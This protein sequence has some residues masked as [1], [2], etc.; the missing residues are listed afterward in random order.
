MQYEIAEAIIGRSDL[1]RP[2]DARDAAILQKWADIVSSNEILRNKTELPEAV[3]HAYGISDSAAKHPTEAIKAWTTLFADVIFRIPYLYTARTDKSGAKVFLYEFK[4]T[5]PFPKGVLWYQ[6]ANHAINDMFVFNAG[7][8][9]VPEK[10]V[11]EYQGAVQMAQKRWLE[12]ASGKTMAW[13]SCAGC[14]KGEEQVFVFANGGESRVTYGLE[15]A[16][17]KEVARRWETLLKAYAE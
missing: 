13:E 8:D 7:E 11:T 4:A 14:E 5:N 12:F 2:Q 16:L 3:R 15:D 17:G 9:M 1:T 6:T 10:H